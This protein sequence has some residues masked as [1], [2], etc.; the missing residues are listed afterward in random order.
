M[1]VKKR[2]ERL[3]ERLSQET[4]RE[5]TEVV[6]CEGE[7]ITVYLLKKPSKTELDQGI[8]EEGRSIPVA[9]VLTIKDLL[10]GR[11]FPEGMVFLRGDQVDVLE[12]LRQKRGKTV[13]P[14]K[15]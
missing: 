14:G 9:E 12:I 5:K 7:L 13:G 6:T 11:E 10:G 2:V 8:T 1:D 3:E 4:T 15:K